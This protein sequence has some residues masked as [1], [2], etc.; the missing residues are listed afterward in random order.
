MNKALRIPFS[1]CVSLGHVSLGTYLSTRKYTFVHIPA[2]SMSDFPSHQFVGWELTF[3]NQG[4]LTGREDIMA[5]RWTLPLN[6]ICL[7]LQ[8]NWRDLQHVGKLSCENCRGNSDIKVPLERVSY[9]VLFDDGIKM[10]ND[11]RLKSYN[12]MFCSRTLS[13][14]Q[15]SVDILI[16][17][18][19]NHVALAIFG[20]ARSSWRTSTI[21]INVT[22]SPWSRLGS[23]HEYH[24]MH[25]NTHVHTNVFCGHFGPEFRP[26][27]WLLSGFWF[28]DVAS[29]L[30]GY[31]LPAAP[32]HSNHHSRP[33]WSI[34]WFTRYGLARD[35][36]RNFVRE[37]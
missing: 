21:I 37:I 32:E 34:C 1:R 23:S 16:W 33:Q 5:P 7:P 29:Q 2:G 30:S 18:V 36:P 13:R 19:C 15:S 12:R 3:G 25:A 17:P 9:T 20:H 28:G 31:I 35:S 22:P 24:S 27:W 11:R 4:W 10:T 8:T 26:R 6:G 14:G